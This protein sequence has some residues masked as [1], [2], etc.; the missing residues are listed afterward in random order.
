MVILEAKAF[1]ISYI[2][3]NVLLILCLEIRR[4]NKVVVVVVVVKSK[5]NVKNFGLEGFEK[6]SN[7]L[8][9]T[10]KRTLT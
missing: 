10:E 8:S 9:S 4:V 2:C 6:Y 3:L 5:S 7:L 1:S